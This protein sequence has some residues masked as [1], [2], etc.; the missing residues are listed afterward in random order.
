M[1]KKKWGDMSP[2]ER[3]AVY[4]QDRRDVFAGIGK[5]LLLIGTYAVQEA[6]GVDLHRKPFKGKRPWEKKWGER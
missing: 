5:E 2:Q 4:K 3:A 6:T 1:A